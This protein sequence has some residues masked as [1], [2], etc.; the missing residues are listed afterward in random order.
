LAHGGPDI[1]RLDEYLPKVAG[2]EAEKLAEYDK[3]VLRLDQYF[4]PKV[5]YVL[6]HTKFREMEQGPNERMDSF[7]VRLREQGANCNY[8]DKLEIVMVDQIV[9]KAKMKYVRDRIR[10]KD[11]SLQGIQAIAASL[12]LQ[13]QSDKPC[14]ANQM[15]RKFSTFEDRR[16][17]YSCGRKGHISTSDKCPAK[18]Q[19]CRKCKIVGHFERQCRKGKRFSSQPDSNMIKKR[20]YNEEKAHLV[21]FEEEEE[22]PY[23]VF[24]I[25]NTGA[26]IQCHIGGVPIKMLT[27]SGA[28][29]NILGYS[30]WENL[31]AKKF[32]FLIQLLEVLERY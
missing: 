19:S 14:E 24:W 11:Y 8:G 29:L 4:R 18:Y 12:E 20:K 2:A 6:E 1:Q 27:D 10:E 31:K 21:E 26:D 32:K 15:E 16:I 9:A 17:C 7:V 5:L 28:D 30:D 13:E 23:N 22:D 3:L 25:G